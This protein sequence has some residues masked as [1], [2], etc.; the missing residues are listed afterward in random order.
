MPKP[1]IARL[2]NEIAGILEL[3]DY[4]DRRPAD[5]SGRQRQRVA[6]GRAIIRHPKVFLFDEV[7]NAAFKRTAQTIICLQHFVSSV[8]IVGIVTAACSAADVV[9]AFV[10]RQGLAKWTNMTSLPQPGCSTPA[11]PSFW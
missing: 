4:L 2:I 5:L 9:H 1:E 11:S 6:M 3:R 8:I 10:Y 7:L